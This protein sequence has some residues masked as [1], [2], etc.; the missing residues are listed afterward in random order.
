MKSL[1]LF[2]ALFSANF[3]FAEP[4]SLGY[5][6]E[7]PMGRLECRDYIQTFAMQNG[8]T[9]EIWGEDDFYLIGSGGKAGNAFFSQGICHIYLN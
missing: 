7:E 8:F 4:K 5:R 3:S 2:A 1:F 9:L 6:L